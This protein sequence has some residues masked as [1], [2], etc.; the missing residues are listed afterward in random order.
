M[1]SPSGQGKNLDIV[2]NEQKIRDAEVTMFK[3]EQKVIK[4]ETQMQN[5]QN[6]DMDIMADVIAKRIDQKANQMLPNVMKKIGQVFN[7]EKRV[8]ILEQKQTMTKMD[9]DVQIAPEEMQFI[10]MQLILIQRE[11]DVQTRTCTAERL[12]RME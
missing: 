5:N 9:N 8:E 4:M 12:D 6:F 11:L 1:T 10:K 3:L 2:F 7:V